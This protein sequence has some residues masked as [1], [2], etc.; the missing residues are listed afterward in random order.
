MPTDENKEAIR[1]YVRDNFDRAKRKR[2]FGL[3]FAS[4]LISV[5]LAIVAWGIS[6]SGAPVHAAMLVLSV[7]LFFALFL[8]GMSMY[9]D[10]T[11]EG[12]RQLT[13]SLVFEARFK[14]AFGGLDRELDEMLD[15]DHE[16]RKRGPMRLTEDGEL[17]SDDEEIDLDLPSS[18]QRSRSS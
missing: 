8:Q 15:A 2:R 14:R 11:R 7:G 17:V 13:R 3:Y 5:I 18:R 10:S 1:Q 4:I 6:L 12:D 16:K 9:L